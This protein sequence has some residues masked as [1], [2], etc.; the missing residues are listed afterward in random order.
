MNIGKTQAVFVPPRGLNIPPDT[1]VMCNSCP[2]Q[3]GTAYKYLDV[4]LD[5]RLSWEAQI[6]HITRKVSQR[7]GPCYA[8]V[9]N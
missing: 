5:N 1:V 9:S 6:L 8:L 4:F 7:L 2:L 3:L